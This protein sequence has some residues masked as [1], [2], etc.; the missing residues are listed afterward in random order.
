[1]NTQ[2]LRCILKRSP[3]TCH[4]PVI[5]VDQLP[6]NVLQYPHGYIVNTRDSTQPG[7]HWVAFW[8]ESPG[9][10]QFFDS[11]GK[12]PGY[13]RHEFT[14]FLKE[15]TVNYEWNTKVLQHDDS[16]TCG[17]YVLFYI[18]LKSKGITLQQIQQRFTSD[19]INDK[20]MYRFAHYY[21]CE[22]LPPSGILM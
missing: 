22:C 20:F 1:M 16:K 2:Q 11:F 12:R 13:Y 4:V 7:K 18:L 19:R 5:S 8:F 10:G 6:A 3:K 14:K 21:F 15:N 9:Y 17:L